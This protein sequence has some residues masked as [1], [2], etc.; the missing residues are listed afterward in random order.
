MSF[1]VFICHAS[2]DKDSFVRPLAEALVSAGLKVWYDEFSLRVGDSLRQA[3]DRGLSQSRYGVVVFSQAFFTKKWSQSEL[4]GLFAKETNDHK[5]ILPV[6]HEIDRDQILSVS[7]LLADR[8]AAL[9]QEGIDRVVSKL[10]DEISPDTVHRTISGKTVFASP[11]E[12]V[13]HRGS[14]AAKTPVVIA[15]QGNRTVYSVWVK[16]ALTG[17]G[18]AAAS[19]A[20]VP[21]LRTTELQ[22]RVGDIKVEADLVRFD[23]LDSHGKEAVFLLFHSLPPK[24]QREI[25]VSGSVPVPSSATVEL[26]G[27]ADEPSAVLEAEGKA[28]IPFTPPEDIKITGTALLMS[29]TS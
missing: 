27:F 15:N 23:A 8:L 20:I 18:V 12:V 29:R 10:L 13:L 2:E 21:D 26:A 17:D 11:P 19:V 3:I 7:P 4:D 25:V 6:W 16:L 14:W 24:T 1:D 22:A 5:V 9:S 28:S